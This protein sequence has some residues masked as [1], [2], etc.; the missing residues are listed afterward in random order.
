LSRAST[1]FVQPEEKDVDGRDKCA[2][3]GHG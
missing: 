2:D 1:F 3:R